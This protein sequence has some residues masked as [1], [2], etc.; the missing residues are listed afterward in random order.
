M[1]RTGAAIPAISDSDLENVF[2]YIPPK[3]ELEKISEN[4]RLSFELRKKA[5]MKI[6]EI[7]LTI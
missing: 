6:T 5:K 1:Y 2:I 3:E 4:V 7:E